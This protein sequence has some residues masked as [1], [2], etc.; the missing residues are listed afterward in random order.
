MCKLKKIDRMILFWPL[1]ENFGKK[2][3]NNN[4][5]PEE[6]VTIHRGIFI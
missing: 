4:K 3:N 1:V 5:K 2:K 6:S